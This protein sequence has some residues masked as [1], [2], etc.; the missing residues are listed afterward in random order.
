MNS[1]N[2]ADTH[3]GEAPNFKENLAR[4]KSIRMALKARE[5]RLPPPHLLNVKCYA[6]VAFIIAFSTGLFSPN[7]YLSIAFAILVSAAVGGYAYK[8]G[9]AARTHEEHL[10]QLL[11]AYEPVAIDAYRALQE[12]IRERRILD[13]DLIKNWVKTEFDAVKISSGRG[14]P[15]ESQFLK[16]TV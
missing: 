7:P 11:A 5:A 6:F 16:K 13:H 4:L 8:F 3:A 1:K 12:K 14:I 10:D 15:S 2:T 9:T